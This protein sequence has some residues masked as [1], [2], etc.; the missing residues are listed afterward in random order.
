MLYLEKESRQKYKHFVREFLRMK[1]SNDKVKKYLHPHLE[2]DFS[3]LNSETVFYT[4]SNSTVLK[5]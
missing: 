4:N 5:L 2:V 3:L 1:F